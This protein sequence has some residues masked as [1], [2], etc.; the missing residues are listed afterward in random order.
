[1]RFT[2]QGKRISLQGLQGDQTQ[3]PVLS[4]VKLKGLLNRSALTHYVQLIGQGDT[5]VGNKEQCS[6]DVVHVLKENDTPGPV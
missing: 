3:C 5:Q 2:Y 4:E 6:V 1:M